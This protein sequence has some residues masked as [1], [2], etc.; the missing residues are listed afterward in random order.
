M[1]ASRGMEILPQNVVGDQTV[2]LTFKR[3]IF[4]A[5]VV[6]RISSASS[7]TYCDFHVEFLW[8]AAISWPEVEVSTPLCTG[9]HLNGVPVRA[10]FRSLGLVIIHVFSTKR[11]RIHDAWPAEGTRTLYPL[12]GPCAH[13]WMAPSSRTLSRWASD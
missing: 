12:R 4:C 7:C 11:I 5:L 6:P 1:G 13:V 8:R 10:V 9:P 2:N 3:W